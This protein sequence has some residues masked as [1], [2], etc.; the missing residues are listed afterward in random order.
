M[1]GRGRRVG[2]SALCTHPLMLKLAE[3]AFCAGV[4]ANCC[5][6]LGVALAK[7]HDC[8]LPIGLDGTGMRRE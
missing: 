6:T 4:L 1:R 2:G 5:V 7:V 8:G 3:L